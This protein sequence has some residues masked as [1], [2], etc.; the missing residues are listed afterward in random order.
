MIY[1]INLNN[2]CMLVC[3][4]LIAKIISNTF[5]SGLRKPSISLIGTKEPRVQR[6]TR[7]HSSKMRTAHLETVRASSFSGHHQISLGEG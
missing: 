1:I 7:K 5:C 4:I 2:M 3:K 6:V